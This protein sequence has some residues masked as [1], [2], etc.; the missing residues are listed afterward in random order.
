M[1]NEYVSSSIAKGSQPLPILNRIT[2]EKE[3]MLLNYKMNSSNS[4]SFGDALKSLI[5]LKLI[6]LTLYDNNLN[7]RTIASI[8][9][10]L[11]QI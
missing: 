2:P 1:M 7:D 8:F 11:S 9:N 6:K 10:S 5:P 4:E 3:M